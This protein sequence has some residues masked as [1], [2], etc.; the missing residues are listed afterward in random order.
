MVKMAMTCEASVCQ[1]RAMAMSLVGPFF[2]GHSFELVRFVATIAR[3]PD[4]TVTFDEAPH[5]S[6]QTLPASGPQTRDT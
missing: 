6:C 2:T 3:P 4:A 1:W 5:R